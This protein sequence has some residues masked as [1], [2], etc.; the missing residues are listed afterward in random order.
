MTIKPFT[1]EEWQRHITEDKRDKFA[2]T[3]VAKC[4][5][6]NAWHRTIGVWDGKELMGGAVVTL[7]KTKPIAANFQ[8]LHV[9]NKHRR[10]GVGRMLTNYC[11]QAALRDGANYFRISADME[12]VDF[13]RKCG[14]KFWGEQKTC[15]L[16]LFK[17]GG[18]NFS[19]AIYEEDEFIGKKLARKGKGALVKRYNK[20]I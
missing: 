15:L 19:D 4:D 1:K 3:F 5:F 9:F 12:A 6:L 11:L 13:Y 10:K 2:K 16:S 7:S 20:P 14:V 17:I 8:L 18:A